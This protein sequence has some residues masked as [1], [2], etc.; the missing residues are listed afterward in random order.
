MVDDDDVWSTRKIT[1][2]EM[3]QLQKN[4][5]SRHEM[6]EISITV[7]ADVSTRIDALIPKMLDA[8]GANDALKYAAALRQILMSGIHALEGEFE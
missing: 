5:D 8:D 1:P 4:L 7:P 3:A 6:V 2:S